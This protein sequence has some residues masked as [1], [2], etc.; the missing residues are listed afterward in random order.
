MRAA[1]VGMVRVRRRASFGQMVVCEGVYSLI[2]SVWEDWYDPYNEFVRMFG[3]VNPC[4]E[5]V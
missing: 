1:R 2:V 3:R 4:R 5:A